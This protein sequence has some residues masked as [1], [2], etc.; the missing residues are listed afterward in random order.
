MNINAKIGLK[1][2]KG[3]RKNKHFAPLMSS[4]IE[5]MHT[6]LFFINGFPIKLGKSM[7][8]PSLEHIVCIE[9]D[10]VEC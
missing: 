9:Y 7:L 8:K 4:L 1:I 2:A 6:V 10:C 5:C 3:K